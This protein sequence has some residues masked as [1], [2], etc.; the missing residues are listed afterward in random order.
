[1]T[2]GRLH[3][4]AAKGFT[5]LEVVLALL[6]LSL[7]VGMVFGTARTSLTLGQSPIS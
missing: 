7:L 5:L 6:L 1:M 4:P 3:P 2:A